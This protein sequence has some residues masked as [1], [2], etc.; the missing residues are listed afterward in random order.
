MEGKNIL[1]KKFFLL[2]FFLEFLI[3]CIIYKVN[4]L[5]IFFGKKES[6]FLI[7]WLKNLLNVFLFVL[8]KIVL[9]VWGILRLRDFNV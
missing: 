9:D 7:F 3:F 1:F 4:L 5:V 8:L 6:V 2:K